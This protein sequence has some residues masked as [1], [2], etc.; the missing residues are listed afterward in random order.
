M[1]IYKFRSIWAKNVNSEYILPDINK[2]ISNNV[3]IPHTV[4]E[5]IRKTKLSVYIGAVGYTIKIKKMKGY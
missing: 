1:D 5:G 4:F 3:I 2:V